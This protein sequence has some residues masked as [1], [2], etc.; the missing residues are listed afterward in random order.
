MVCFIRLSELLPIYR[1][2]VQIF[3]FSVVSID[4]MRNHFIQTFV[5]WKNKTYD[6]RISN[7]EL[8][9]CFYGNGEVFRCNEIPKFFWLYCYGGSFKISCVLL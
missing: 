8:Y 4:V 5:F 6:F 3:W 9:L 2:N 1:Q 7:L